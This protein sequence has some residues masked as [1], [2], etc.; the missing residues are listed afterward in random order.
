VT[1][2]IRPVDPPRKVD[3]LIVGGLTID[4]LDRHMQAAGGAARYA[5]EGA[6]A[7]GLEVALLTVSGD[8][9][10]AR[11]AIETLAVNAGVVR[12]PAP[13][14]IRFEHH[15]SG[16]PRRLRLLARG[17]GV[18]IRDRGH[19]PDA[20]AVLFA[21]V[22]EEVPAT[23]L[24]AIRA[25]FRAAG[26]QGWL[27][28]TDAE[29]WVV[30]KHL[31]DLDTQLA[32]ALRALELL[33]AS[34]Q[35]LGAPDGRTALAELRGWAGA[36]PELVVTAGADGAWLD[37]GRDPPVRVPVD[38]VAGRHTIGAGDAF[39]AVLAARRGAGIDLRTAADEATAATARY[40]AT[41]PAPG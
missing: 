20:G 38:A 40:L 13:T 4:D 22:A 34:L 18:Q 10:I 41:R 16:E 3:L 30:L 9:P 6:V 14:S 29:G 26:I 12:E 5:T 27:R 1:D 19:V 39:A 31:A 17:G 32:D 11:A 36:S 37:D 25:P 15:G 23:I 28:K 8:E 2:D 21:P 7:A 24:A 33:V 35:D